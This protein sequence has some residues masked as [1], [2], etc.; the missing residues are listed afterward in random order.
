MTNVVPLRRDDGDLAA[1]VDEWLAEY[2]NSN[3]RERYGGSVRLVAAH[4]RAMTPNDFTPA[5]V[6]AWAAD[7]IGANNTVR[8]HVSAI[9]NF[10]RWC[11]ETGNLTRY[12]DRPMQRILRSYPPTYGKVQSHRPANRLDAAGYTALIA[13]CQDGSDAGLRDELM[14]RLGVSG[15][16]RVNELRT[17]TVAGLLTA[18]DLRWT[19]KAKK[20]RTAKAGPELVALIDRYL[21]RYA[22]AIGGQEPRPSSPALCATLHPRNPSAVAWGQPVRQNDTLSRN[23]RKRANAAGLGWMAAHDLKRTAGRMMHEARS[24]DGGHLF[25]LLDIADVLDHDNPKVTKDCYIGPLGS[26]NKD[27]AAALFG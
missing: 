14:V 9:R 10:L 8:G 22:E 19:G 23:L 26:E 25:D 11:E 3:T 16:M 5:A 15:G 7:Y 21:I 12:R 27:R 20:Q 1:L 18:P 13:A 17:L 6:A 4:A 2:S 24:A